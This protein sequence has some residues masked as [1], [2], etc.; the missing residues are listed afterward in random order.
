M[1]I[2][3]VIVARL[4]QAAPELKIDWTKM[5]TYN[6]IMAVA[7][8][9]GLLLAGLAFTLFGALNYFTHIGLIVNTM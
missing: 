1:A 5:P 3:G 9:V 8:G 2:A 4:V 7:A 6:T